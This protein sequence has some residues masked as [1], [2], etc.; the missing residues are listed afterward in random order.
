[1]KRS[2]SH[3]GSGPRILGGRL[4]GRRL[5]VAKG[6]RPSES[7]LREALFSIWLGQL[8]ASRFLDL[9]AGS[10]AVGLEALSRGAHHV[11]FVE[12]AAPVVAALRRNLRLAPADSTTLWRASLPDGLDA[13]PEWG[14]FDL[15]FA[16]PPYRFT[17]YPELVQRAIGW[18]APGGELVIEHSRR[19]ELAPSVAAG[20]RCD[21]RC[22]GDS[23]LSFFRSS[24][25]RQAPAH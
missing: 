5:Q 12:R 20:Q 22:Y 14:P 19:V 16:D 6:V 3:S 13:R 4:R 8:E 18:L 9:F 25:E 15:I 23:C 24:S 17:Q 11:T 10:G 2:G 21:H 1:M 7:R